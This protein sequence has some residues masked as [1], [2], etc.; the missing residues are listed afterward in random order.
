[1]VITREQWIKKLSQQSGF[2]QKDI[3]VLLDIMEET[4]LEYFDQATEEESVS[5]QAMK[6]IKI[7]C[8]IVPQRERIHPTTR[9]PIMCT[10]QTKPFAKF[11]INLRDEL[12]NRFE[13]KQ[14]DK[15]DG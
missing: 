3:R 12:Q 7:G 6:G 4:M 2:W 1:M 11:S 5:I 15:Q 13:E 10:P 8:K 14:Q 9:L